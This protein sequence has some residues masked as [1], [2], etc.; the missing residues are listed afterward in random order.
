MVRILHRRAEKERKTY[1]R[2]T[3]T[4]PICFRIPTGRSLEISDH[5]GGQGEANKLMTDLV[6]YIVGLLSLAAAKSVRPVD[7][8][9]TGQHSQ[10][11]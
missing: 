8:S 3:P 9:S 4:S 6:R 2:A 5:A 1:V 10:R 7:V 11:Q